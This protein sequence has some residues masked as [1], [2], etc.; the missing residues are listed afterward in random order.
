MSLLLVSVHVEVLVSCLCPAAVSAACCGWHVRHVHR[1]SHR[2][3]TADQTRTSSHTRHTTN[4]IQHTKTHTLT[5]TLIVAGCMYKFLI[6]KWFAIVLCCCVNERP[7]LDTYLVGRTL[8]EYVAHMGAGHNLESAA[9]HPGLEGQLQ[10]L[11]A[12]DI[13]ARVVSA[14]SFEEL[15]V[16]R[17]QTSSHCRRVDGLRCALQINKKWKI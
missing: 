3:A 10:I 15:A 1:G 7:G 5:R 16:Y 6:L 11:A 14:Q 2:W 12:P 17:K 4:R 9:A 8:A 13:E